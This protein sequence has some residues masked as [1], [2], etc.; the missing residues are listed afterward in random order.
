MTIKNEFRSR[1]HHIQQNQVGQGTLGNLQGFFSAGGHL[2]LVSGILQGTTQNV[3]VL[4]GIIYNQYPGFLQ[5]YGWFIHNGF[6]TERLDRLPCG[7]PAVFGEGCFLWV[8]R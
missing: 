4:G 7:N 6:L 3:Q 1:H 2:N 8:S 5:I